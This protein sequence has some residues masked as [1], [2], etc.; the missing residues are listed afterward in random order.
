MPTATTS[1]LPRLQNHLKATA[2][3]SPP[4]FHSEYVF[5]ATTTPTMTLPPPRLYN[6]HVT[7][8]TFP[9]LP[10]RLHHLQDHHVT[11]AI[12]S[13][14]E[15]LFHV[16]KA[17]TI[18]PPRLYNHLQVSTANKSKHH[19]VPTPPRFQKQHYT[20]TSPTTPPPVLHI[21]HV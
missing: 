18:P 17:S 6:T 8:T 21:H 11:L 2:P 10:P 4:R 9:P 1:K 15:R 3:M 5:N 19:H 7:T 20:T 14:P 13:P 16:I 12:T